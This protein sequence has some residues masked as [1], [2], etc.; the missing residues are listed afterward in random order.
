MFEQWVRFSKDG[1]FSSEFPAQYVRL[2]GG[3]MSQC[4]SFMNITHEMNDHQL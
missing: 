3:A 2:G 4:R 1:W